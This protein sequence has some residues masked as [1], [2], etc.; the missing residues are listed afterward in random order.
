MKGLL[1]KSYD[2]WNYHLE[3]QHI[4]LGIF[5]LNFQTQKILLPLKEKKE[6][7]EKKEYN[8]KKKSNLTEPVKKKKVKNIKKVNLNI[9]SCR[10]NKCLSMK[11]IYFFRVFKPYLTSIHLNFY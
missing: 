2:I 11:L 3:Q 4:V 10:E 9:F 7:Y 5:Y 8:K 1:D 6:K